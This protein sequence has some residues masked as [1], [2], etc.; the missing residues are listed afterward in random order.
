MTLTRQEMFDKVATHLLTQ[1]ERSVEG[2][3][4]RYRLGTLKCAIGAL[5]PDDKYLRRFEDVAIDGFS[6]EALLL[7]NVAGISDDDAKFARRLQRVHDNHRPEEWASELHLFAADYHLST[8][9][10]TNFS[11]PATQTEQL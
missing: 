4:C 8:D 1:M 9:V 5:I 10:I 2:R 7:R 3:L 6:Q 11:R